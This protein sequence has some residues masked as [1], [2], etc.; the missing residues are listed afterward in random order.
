MDIGGKFYTKAPKTCQIISN[1]AP[2][3]EDFALHFKSFDFKL[4]LSTQML[5]SR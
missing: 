2:L 4:K 3:N 5:T 1:F